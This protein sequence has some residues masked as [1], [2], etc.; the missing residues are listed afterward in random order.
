MKERKGESPTDNW[1]TK[2]GPTDLWA[3]HLLT[4][5]HVPM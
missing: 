5:P 2:H 1:P 3:E 4:T